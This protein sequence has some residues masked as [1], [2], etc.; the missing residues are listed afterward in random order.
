[1]I[2]RKLISAFNDKANLVN[3]VPFIQN[4]YGDSE[5]PLYRC[6]EIQT[7]NFRQGFDFFSNQIFAL[8]KEFNKQYSAKAYSVLLL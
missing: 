1:M 8:F 5:S 4:L 3:P 2:F 6:C 7:S